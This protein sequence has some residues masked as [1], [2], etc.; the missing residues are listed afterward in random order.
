MPMAAA[1]ATHKRSPPAS[2]AKAFG[3][4]LRIASLQP[5]VLEASTLFVC[6]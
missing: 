3:R 5:S 6:V 1:N 2:Q 4:E